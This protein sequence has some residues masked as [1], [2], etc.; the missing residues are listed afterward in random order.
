MTTYILPQPTATPQPGQVIIN[1][2]GAPQTPNTATLIQSTAHNT[3]HNPSTNSSNTTGRRNTPPSNHH[4]SNNGNR[5]NN[6]IVSSSTTIQATAVPLQTFPTSAPLPTEAGQVPGPQTIYALPPSMYQNVLPYQTAPATA[7]FYQPLPHP[8]ANTTIISSVIPH[9]NPPPPPPP[10]SGTLPSTPHS[11]QSNAGTHITSSGE[12]VTHFPFTHTSSNNQQSTNNAAS[13]PQSTPST[14]ITIQQNFKNPPLFATPPIIASVSTTPSLH[15][16]KNNSSGSGVYLPK[17]YNGNNGVMNTPPPTKSNT[18]YSIGGGYQ[19]NNNNNNNNSTL[20]NAQGGKKNMNYNPSNPNNNSNANNN[21]NNSNNNNSSNSSSEDTSSLTLNSNS[22]N[23]NYRAKNRDQSSA[24][25]NNYQPKTSSYIPKG[26]QQ[27]QQH[28]NYSNSQSPN[29]NEN[30][31]ESTGK[32][33][34]RGP[35]RAVPPSLDLKRNN[36]NTNVMTNNYHHHNR[37]TPSTN[38]TES[39]NSPNSITSYDHSRNFHYS[40]N[41]APTHFITQRGGSAGPSDPPMPTYFPFNVQNPGA[42]AQL[43]DPCQNQALIGYNNTG[44][45]VKLGPAVTF[46]S[47]NIIIEEYEVKFD[48]KF[49]DLFQ[50]PNPNSRK[51]PSND[52]RMVS[53]IYTMPMLPGKYKQ[54]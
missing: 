45:Y 43:I 41:P 9:T 46:A 47:V 8:P 26:Q 38:S 18:R 40:H 21:S 16:E 29:S 34:H 7:S 54:I 30:V 51:S 23:N 42:S 13:T 12:V 37:S 35:S 5:D 11:Y 10:Q 14:P 52:M 27:Q 44:M 4:N 19:Q 53:G 33:V 1:Q 50:Q 48:Y 22:T 39:N 28:S 17:K 3:L 15:M 20:G 31:N 32:Y 6:H 24:G 2:P 49:F 25:S 36:S